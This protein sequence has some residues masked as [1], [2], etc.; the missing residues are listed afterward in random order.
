MSNEP[1]LING[2]IKNDVE[3]LENICI[4]NTVD[5]IDFSFFHNLSKY[6]EWHDYDELCNM[7]RNFFSNYGN[8][9]WLDN[10]YINPCH[11][12][13]YRDK[14]EIGIFFDKEKELFLS[15]SIMVDLNQKF[16]TFFFI[17]Y[18]ERISTGSDKPAFHNEK[19]F[20]PFFFEQP[21][22][23]PD[24]LETFKRCNNRI[25]NYKIKEQ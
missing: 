3:R 1:E 8:I 2:Y 25:F 23:N 17:E 21:I 10:A 15:M 7:I 19:S 6:N 11:Y 16:I 24:F 22:N 13:E 4:A 14:V 5:Y 18:N 12:G 9:N 20:G